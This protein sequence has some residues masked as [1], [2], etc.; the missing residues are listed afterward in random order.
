MGQ[1]YL[2]C[3]EKSDGIWRMTVDDRQLDKVTPP[4]TAAQP[5]IITSIEQIQAC[6]G[7]CYTVTDRAIAFFFFLP[8]LFLLSLGIDLSSHGKAVSL[9]LPGCL[10]V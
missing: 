2:A 4:L 3:G 10:R 6:A 9:Y 1:F 7:T 5:D 8:S